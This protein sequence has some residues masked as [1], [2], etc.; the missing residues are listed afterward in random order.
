M[1]SFWIVLFTATVSQGIFLSIVLGMKQQWKNKAVNMLSL[2]ILSFTLTLAYYLSFWLQIVQYLPPVFS[3]S[4]QFTLLFGP[5]LWIYFCKVRNKPAPRVWLHFIPFLIAVVA[6]VISNGTQYIRTVGFS[7]ILLQNAQLVGYTVAMLLIVKDSALRV[8]VYAFA[9][10]AAC[11]LSYYVLVWT[12][13]LQLQYD[14]MVSL[15][16]AVFIY[17]IG[18]RGLKTDSFVPA[19]NGE[20]Y[21][22]SALTS[23]ALQYIIQKLDQVMDK[24]KLYLNGDLKLQDLAD[25]LDV[26][27]HSLSQAINAG[28]Q[29]KFNDYLNELRVQEAKRLMSSESHRELKLIAI[30]LDSGFNNKT[31]F[32]NAFKKHTGV[33]PSAYREK[34]LA[35]AS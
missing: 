30:A 6:L 14:Y 16:M 19:E 20:K 17:S 25:E 28:K 1:P 2:L 8:L 23:D 3:L 35:Q 21:S 32:L 4:M 15:G 12:G 24:E 7:V 11:F 13:T 29:Q 9:G 26:S 27:I 33:S 31:S 22:N 5:L 34:L 18:Y 10:Y